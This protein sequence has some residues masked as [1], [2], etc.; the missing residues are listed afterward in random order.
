MTQPQCIYNDNKNIIKNLDL[1]KTKHFSV[2][3]WTALDNKNSI[4]FQMLSPTM[5]NFVINIFIHFEYNIADLRDCNEF[6]RH[7][8]KYITYI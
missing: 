5:N 6:Y 7:G 3:F 2:D 1:I 4:Y 8:Y